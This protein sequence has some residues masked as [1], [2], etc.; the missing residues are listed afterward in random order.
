M[1]RPIDSDRLAFHRLVFARRRSGWWTPLAVGALGIILFLLMVLVVSL[2]AIL[3]ALSNDD[4]ARALNRVLDDPGALDVTN[5]LSL[6]IGLGSVALLLPAYLL[7]SLIVNGRRLGFVSAVF[8]RLRWRWLLVCSGL[9]VAVALVVTLVTALLPAEDP[10]A[11]LTPPTGGALWLSLLVVVLVVPVQATAEEY[12]FRGYLMQ[13]IG[14]WLRHPLFAILLPV[15]LFVIGHL[16][17]PVG[18]AGVALF[19]IAAGW[20][21]WRTGGLEAAIAVHI[22]NNLLAFVTGIVAGSDPSATDVGWVSFATSVLLLGGYCLAVEYVLRRRPIART[23][24]MPRT[25]MPAPI[26]MPTPTATVP[27]PGEPTPELTKP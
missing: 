19:A 22:V 12:V 6:L 25:P 2:A 26:P 27:L 11:Q 4:A 15:P 24:A 9:G 3:V 8:G 20:L 5:P 7:A 1:P 17:D 10:G 23:Y 14:R 18:Q 13:S 16:Y 21:T